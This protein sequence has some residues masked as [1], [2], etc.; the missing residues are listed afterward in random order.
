MGSITLSARTLKSRSSP[1][2]LGCLAALRAANKANADFQKKWGKGTTLGKLTEKMPDG[3]LYKTS[4]SASLTAY[5]NKNNAGSL[6]KLLGELRLGGP[7][8]KEIARQLSDLPMTEALEAALKGGG[9]EF[10]DRAF[11]S[12][13]DKISPDAQ[14][15]LW[16]PGRAKEV[17]AAIKA[18]GLRGTKPI[19]KGNLNNSGSA[20]SLHNIAQP[21]IRLSAGLGALGG[22]AFNMI[23]GFGR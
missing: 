6:K 12:V 3:D 11:K 14:K 17:N 10:N 5:L 22:R 21:A 9:E 2:R 18:W 23:K 4:P 16:G 19:Q 15:S 7:A 8:E 1:A 13:I 20:K